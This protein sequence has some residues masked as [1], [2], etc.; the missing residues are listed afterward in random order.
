MCMSDFSPETEQ[1]NPADFCLLHFE[2][3]SGQDKK[4]ERH[5]HL[6][7]RVVKNLLPDNLISFGNGSGETAGN[8]LPTSWFGYVG[9]GDWGFNHLTVVCMSS[10]SYCLEEVA[11]YDVTNKCIVGWNCW[12]ASHLSLT[13]D[14][15]RKRSRHT[16]TKK[17]IA[18]QF[19]SISIWNSRMFTRGLHQVFGAHKWL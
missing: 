12:I 15:I 19:K 17:K 3:W 7:F 6:T 4:H 10:T 16:R 9:R 5:L 11:R 13:V 18:R 1:H 14:Y 2:S 8:K